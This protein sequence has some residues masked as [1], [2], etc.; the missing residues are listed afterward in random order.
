MKRAKKHRKR[1]ILPGPLG[2]R[3]Q[4][5]RQ[6]M[7]Q[8]NNEPNADTEITTTDTRSLDSNG[9]N[10]NHDHAASNTN[11]NDNTNSLTTNKI[12]EHVQIWDAMCISLNRII[13]SSIPTFQEYRKL[14]D[15]QHEYTLLADIPHLPF[16]KI[17][18]IV[19]QI[20]QIHAHGHC[21]YT[22]ELLDESS[23]LDNS[24]QTEVGWLSQGLIRNHPEWIRPGTVFLCQ[25]VSLA[26]FSIDEQQ[27]NSN[28][29]GKGKKE[30]DRML[31]LG[32]HNI[33][34]AWTKDSIADVDHGQYLDLLERRSEVSQGLHWGQ[35]NTTRTRSEESVAIAMIHD[36]QAGENEAD[37]GNGMEE[38]ELLVDQQVPQQ[39]IANPYRK[40]NHTLSDGTGN[41]EHDDNGNEENEFLEED[42]WAKIPA[43]STMDN[44]VNQ[45]EATV[46]IDRGRVDTL[47]AM[48]NQSRQS[49]T[50]RKDINSVVAASRSADTSNE[51]V[52]ATNVPM[53]DETSTMLIR[54]S[55]NAN[56]N[57]DSSSI[58]RGNQ[59]GRQTTIIAGEHRRLVHSAGRSIESIHDTGNSTNGNS[60][61]RVPSQTNGR[62]DSSN[63]GNDRQP[64]SVPSKVNPYC[65]PS[66]RN[67]N[68]SNQEPQQEQEQPSTSIQKHNPCLS[69]DSG[70]LA[71]SSFI[72]NPYTKIA[73]SQGQSQLQSNLQSSSRQS[74]NQAMP[75]QNRNNMSIS[76]QNVSTKTSNI[77]RHP[78]PASI[79]PNE[80]DTS[81]AHASPSNA[82]ASIRQSNNGINNPYKQKSINPFVSSMQYPAVSQNT[83]CRVEAPTA[84]TTM[85][86]LQNHP[87]SVMLTP[88]LTPAPQ[89]ARLVHTPHQTS[90]QRSQVRVE[91]TVPLYESLQDNAHNESIWNSVE[92][93]TVDMNAFIDE[94][95][96]NALTTTYFTSDVDAGDAAAGNTTSKNNLQ[97]IKESSGQ[98]TVS[99]FTNLGNLQDNEFDAF[100]EED[101]D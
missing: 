80:R 65:T 70:R 89:L 10:T 68:H 13:P 92:S 91:A 36:L 55:A 81:T 39:A 95:E 47:A 1:H 31:V 35:G 21:D 16:P 4:R 12:H 20:S 30:F 38:V 86:Q 23:F 34:Y 82:I 5:L 84:A 28:G 62:I 49:Q 66:N 54:S 76:N 14:F 50:R 77:N 67:R 42:E 64:A 63:D 6:R 15:P 83:P 11:T 26:V 3:Q 40:S 57:N 46:V 59:E 44:G 48:A 96:N 98:A 25:Q 17:P 27:W 75:S 71:Q 73:S 79:T 7:T 24:S 56:Q 99:L 101:D 78:T 37:G 58:Q 90:I 97:G 85:Q 45:N 72:V 29:N 94:E 88:T 52:N 18:K 60:H 2:L 53:Q 87:R 51:T 100:E 43:S 74:M 9:D 19:L 22:V 33:I 8:E 61:V 32:E 69:S 93:H 41:G